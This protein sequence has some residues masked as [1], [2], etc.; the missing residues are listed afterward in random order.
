MITWTSRIARVDGQI[1][2]G[3][4]GVA[5]TYQ[6][7]LLFFIPNERID[8]PSSGTEELQQPKNHGG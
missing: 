4:G 5:K 3:G 8:P 2:P 6:K 7:N 1:K